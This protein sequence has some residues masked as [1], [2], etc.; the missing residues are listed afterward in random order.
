MPEAAVNAVSEAAEALRSANHALL[1][2]DDF[3]H[4]DLYRLVGELSQLCQRLPQLLDSA[5]EILLR[6]HAAGR[7]DVDR[8]DVDTTMAAWRAATSAGSASA[9]EL[10]RHVNDAFTELSIVKAAATVDP[11]H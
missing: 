5:G 7:V 11:V 10:S 3:D 4:Q 1:H 2:V 9:R 6:R 8:G